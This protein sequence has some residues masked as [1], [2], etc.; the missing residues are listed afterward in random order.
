MW[1]EKNVEDFFLKIFCEHEK[2]NFFRM[3]QAGGSGN[4]PNSFE[5]I[6]S[7]GGF[8]SLPLSLLW[9]EKTRRN[10]FFEKKKGETGLL[11]QK[12]LFRFLEV[13]D[14]KPTNQKRRRRREMMIYIYI[15]DHFFCLFLK[16]SWMRGGIFC[17]LILVQ[18]TEKEATSFF[19]QKKNVFNRKKKMFCVPPPKLILGGDFF[20][21]R[22]FFEK[23]RAILWRRTRF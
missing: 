10:I 8:L 18:K 1:E 14:E 3:P 4:F 7:Q 6:F 15:Y 17:H 22:W 9:G 16:S 12:T 5:F 23:K 13:R 11:F 20:L 19:T 2:I 21:F